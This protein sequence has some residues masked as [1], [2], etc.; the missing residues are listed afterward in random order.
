MAPATPGCSEE[1]A[2]YLMLESFTGGA[3]GRK[4]KA[5][6]VLSRPHLPHAEGS[7]PSGHHCLLFLLHLVTR[8]RSSLFAFPWR[9]SLPSA[10]G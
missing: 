10:Q 3:Q 7:P 1:Q 2:R 9:D 8:S 5:L 4:G 6:Q